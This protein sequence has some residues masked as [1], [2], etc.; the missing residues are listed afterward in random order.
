MAQRAEVGDLVLYKYVNLVL[1]IYI[2][3]TLDFFELG[4]LRSSIS[5]LDKKGLYLLSY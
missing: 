4:R 5:F 3:K 1:N 2:F